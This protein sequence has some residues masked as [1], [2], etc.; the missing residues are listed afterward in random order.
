MY[1]GIT[2]NRIL[3][4][5]T[6]ANSL[7][8]VWGT[9]DTSL[10]ARYSVS[11]S[12]LSDTKFNDNVT[13]VVEQNVT[14]LDTA[15]NTITVDR[16]MPLTRYN[17][18]VVEHNVDNTSTEACKEATTSSQDDDGPDVIIG[19]S[20]S[21]FVMMLITLL[22]SSVLLMIIIKQQRNGAKIEKW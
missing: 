6:G 9:Q 13:S 5:L 1:A 3:I 4:I 21:L 8:V 10:V 20:I 14:V 16:L 15:I 12:S 11:C 22:C 17:C 7:Q 2:S 18:C 19:A